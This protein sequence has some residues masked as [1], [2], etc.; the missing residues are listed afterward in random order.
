[1][2]I[3]TALVAIG[4]STTDPKLEPLSLD[5][6]KFPRFVFMCATDTEVLGLMDVRY[7]ERGKY[8]KF[9]ET[10]KPDKPTFT[11]AITSAAQS[12][13]AE[14]LLI[15]VRTGVQSNGSKAVVLLRADN[16]GTSATY[17][18]KTDTETSGT[19]RSVPAPPDKT[20]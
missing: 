17:E 3:L 19:C 11:A 6:L 9:I 12:K 18:L 7:D 20:S 14:R 2:I 1:M 16:S 10:N 5:A 4:V 15:Q 8:L 13:D